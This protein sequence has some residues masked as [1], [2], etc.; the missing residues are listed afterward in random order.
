MRFEEVR[1]YIAARMSTF[2]GIDQARIQYPNQPQE[3]KTP[4]SGLWCRLNIQHAP[5][6]MAGMADKPYTRKPG[7]IVIQCFARVRT[8]IK[9]LNELADALEAH[10][11]YWSQGDLECIETG[12]ID[13]GEFDGFYQINVVTRF[14]AG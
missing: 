9:G 7:Q 11:S 13:A 6:F 14:R 2:D 1:Q 12:Q 4:E 5:S 10:F 3:F 8:G